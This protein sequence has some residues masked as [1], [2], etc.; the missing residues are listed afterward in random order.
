M[1]LPCDPAALLMAVRPVSA[2][3]TCLHRN[4]HAKL[5]TGQMSVHQLMNEYTKYGAFIQWDTVESPQNEIFLQYGGTSKRLHKVKNASHKSPACINPFLG[6]VWNRQTHGDR[7]Q[8]SGAGGR[9]QGTGSDGQRH[10]V[11][12]LDDGDALVKLFVVVAQPCE[13]TGNH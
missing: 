1:E 12:S 2:Q 7:R 5:E 9:R 6:N 4:S 11:S 8:M 13:Y 3:E 10:G